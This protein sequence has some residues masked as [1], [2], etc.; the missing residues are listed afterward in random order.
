MELQLGSDP[1]PGNSICHRV[2]KKEKRKKQKT[3]CQLCK[4]RDVPL[5]HYYIVPIS[6]EV[7]NEFKNYNMLKHK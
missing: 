1:W 5:V 4:S 6:D 7:K 3:E 2:A